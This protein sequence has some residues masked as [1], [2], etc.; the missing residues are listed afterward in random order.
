MKTIIKNYVYDND[1]KFIFNNC[2]YYGPKTFL[3][4][5]R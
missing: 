5:I 4:D 2:T 3:F 1:L